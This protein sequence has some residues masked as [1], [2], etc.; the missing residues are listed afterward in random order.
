MGTCVQIIIKL[1][2]YLAPSTPLL[3]LVFNRRALY[4]SK[5]AHFKIKFDKEVSG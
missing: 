3:L 5:L 2:G 4:Q 1:L